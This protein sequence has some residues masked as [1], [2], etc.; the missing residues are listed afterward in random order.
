MCAHR[1]TQYAKFMLRLVMRNIAVFKEDQCKREAL[2]KVQRALWGKSAHVAHIAIFP[3]CPPIGEDRA[4]RMQHLDFRPD[5]F[6][7][8]P[9]TTYRQVRVLLSNLR[10]RPAVMPEFGVT[11]LELLLLEQAGGATDLPGQHN[12]PEELG[13]SIEQSLSIS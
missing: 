10:V 12:G 2:L 5:G 1:E 6:T 8:G 7:K 4:I 9:H 11:W 13:M 3:S